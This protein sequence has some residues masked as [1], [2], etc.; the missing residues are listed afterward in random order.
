M[1]NKATLAVLVAGIVLPSGTKA[2]A[3]PNWTHIG[4]AAIELGLADLATGPVQR[5][6][7][8][9]DGTLLLIRTASGKIFETNDFET[10]RT[11]TPDTVVPPIPVTGVTNPPEVRAQIRQSTGSRLYA[12][13]T[14]VYRSDD[15]G[16]H[17]SNMTAFRSR[18]F[19]GGP[20]AD[21]AVS[22]L[23]PDEIVAVG[24]DGAFRSL[25]GG[26][27]W[28]GLNEGLPNLP[29]AHILALPLGSNGLQAELGGALSAEWRPGERRA[30]RPVDNLQA[31]EES[32]LR[33]ALSLQW[34]TTVT[35]VTIVGDYVYAGTA[36]GVIRVSSNRGATW[37]NSQVSSGGAVTAFSVAPGNPQ[38]A[39]ATLSSRQH[40]AGVPPAHVVG[41]ISA[42]RLWD[43]LSGGLADA[44][45]YGITA[46]WSGNAVYVA[47]EGGVFWSR[48]NL[49]TMS[50]APWAP[51]AGLPTTAATDVRLDAGANR[52]WVALRG[53][54]MYEGFA[55]HRNGD[56]RVVSSAD[57][58]SRAAA[59][60]ALVS[61]P[62]ARVNS[63]SVGQFAAPVLDANDAESQ[64]QIPF[65]VTG[66][67]LALSIEADG[68]QI[69]FSL[70]MGLT[71][72]AIWVNSDGSPLLLD[73]D[74]FMLD[75]TRPAHARER[76]Q[77]LATGLGA[78]QQDWPA[79]AP[80]PLDTP[81]R[82]VTNVTA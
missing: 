60:G 73:A 14:Y 55:P 48:V 59:P 80:A 50:A 28:A 70:S 62:G 40:A 35:A 13:G 52:L 22:P 10:W 2:Q 38:S 43:P 61:I 78:L 45:A 21:L 29:D 79:G 11:T 19:I 33:G 49:T 58:S 71:S 25:D 16:A 69:S 12:F 31:D 41:T 81:P 72:P 77:I 44:P 18:S 67:T 8:S 54:G 37:Q 23:N 63:A 15:M 47:T 24:N 9:G 1:G 32:R 6:W 75:A 57:Y 53:E 20:L 66:S 26:E 51:L 82:A 56:P 42:G 4:N 7:Y 64:I 36:E 46:D 17:W 39:L 76:I 65:G 3:P 34:D 27:V 68:R 30:W 5:V 74:N